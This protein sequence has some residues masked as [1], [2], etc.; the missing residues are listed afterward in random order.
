MQRN[1]ANRPQQANGPKRSSVHSQLTANSFKQRLSGYTEITPVDLLE[2]R[3]GQVRYAIETLD[4]A[5]QAV[6]TVYRLGGTLTRVDPDLRFLR[7]LNPYAKRSWSVQL[8]RPRGERVRL[9]YRPPATMEEAL[10]MRKLL[11]GIETN[12]IKIVR[13]A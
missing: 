2:A 10:M 13:T 11:R 7:L 3:G 5:G 9:W 1:N 6:S 8:K 4:P 12:Q